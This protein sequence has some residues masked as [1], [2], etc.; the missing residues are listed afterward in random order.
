MRERSLCSSSLFSLWTMCIFILWLS[1]CHHLPLEILLNGV[2]PS[3]YLIYSYIFSFQKNRLDVRSMKLTYSFFHLPWDFG[4]VIS[5]LSFY[6]LI[7]RLGQFKVPLGIAESNKR[8]C[9]LRTAKGHS[10]SRHQDQI[11]CGTK[12]LF[13]AI[14]SGCLHIIKGFVT[15]AILTPWFYAL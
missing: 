1:R 9:S 13:G 4:C 15:S 11:V 2:F 12:L 10:H 5:S 6:Y 7:C 8:G 3:I 14:K